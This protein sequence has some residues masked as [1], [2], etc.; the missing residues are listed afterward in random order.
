MVAGW[1]LSL[2]MVLANVEGVSPTWNESTVATYS[3]VRLA[4]DV[5]CELVGDQVVVLIPARSE[6][7]SLSGAQA[8][9]VRRLQEGQ[10]LSGSDD[11]HVRE[12]IAA[13]VAVTDMSRR[14]LLVGSGLAVGAGMTAMSLPAVAVSSS[15][16][17][18]PVS[19]GGGDPLEIERIFVYLRN[20][21][22]PSVGTAATLRIIKGSFDRTIDM[23]FKTNPDIGK[24]P[25][26]DGFE[27]NPTPI[28]PPIAGSDYLG[29]T[30]IL[31]FN[32]IT[33]TGQAPTFIP[34]FD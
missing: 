17:I 14:S 27:N 2:Q 18:F 31:T 8:E 4:P 7:I 1:A 13:G 29:S 19:E 24:F 21:A 22:V 20:V 16:S 3:G 11:A 25:P 26:E 32:G 30:L 6:V 10:T 12:L 28:N 33:I 5:I 34:T 9:I 23:I 15:A